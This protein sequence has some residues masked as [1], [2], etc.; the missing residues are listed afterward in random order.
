LA[1]F[2]SFNRLASSLPGLN[3]NIAYF[4]FQWPKSDIASGKSQ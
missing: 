2:V 4:S 3:Q 1:I